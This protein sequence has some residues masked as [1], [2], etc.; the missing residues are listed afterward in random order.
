V[1]LP[2]LTT[3]T[4]TLSAS[5]GLFCPDQ[6]APGAFGVSAVRSIIEVGVPPGGSTNALAMDLAA[7]FCVPATGSPIDFFTQ[8][9]A[10][11][12]LSA[13]GQLDLSSVLP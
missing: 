2:N 6:P 9:P 1:V 4:S 13:A 12:G 7:T 11:G 5:D 3:G 10:A 8:L